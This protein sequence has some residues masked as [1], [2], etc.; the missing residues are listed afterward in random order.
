MKKVVLSGYFGFDNFGDEKVLS[1]IVDTLKSQGAYITVLSRNPKKTSAL[2]GVESVGSFNPI[3]L[4]QK[5]MFCDVLVSGGGSLLQDVTSVKSLFYYLGIIFLGLLFRKKVMLY[6]QGI[7]P[8]RTPIG[9]WWTKFLLKRVNNIAVRDQRSF[10][11]LSK[12]GIDAVLTADA[13][14]GLEFPEREKKNQVVIQLRSWSGMNKEKIQ[15]IKIQNIA[16]VIAEDF[17]GYNIKILPLQISS[18]MNVCRKMQ[19][20]LKL[21]NIDAELFINL[22][23]DDIIRVISESRFVI[24]M[25]Y[26][27][28]LVAIKSGARVLAISYD[29]KVENLASQANIP[30]IPVEIINRGFSNAVENM[31]AYSQQGSSFFCLKEVTKSRQNNELQNLDKIMSCCVKY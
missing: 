6:S 25:R 3:A 31:K 8:I 21:R 23:C 13:L 19:Q 12:A 1:I 24:A 4:L 14:W 16:D 22:S 2:Y 10:N 7:G 9:R 27:A 15:N 18:D 29:I 20:E 28:C 5:I 26:H 11:E 17:R 30:L